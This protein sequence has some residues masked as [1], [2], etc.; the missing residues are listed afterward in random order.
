MI[1]FKGMALMSLKMSVFWVV[2][3]ARN[4]EKDLHLKGA[5][6]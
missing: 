1:A 5:G 4:F 3:L 2:K 6:K